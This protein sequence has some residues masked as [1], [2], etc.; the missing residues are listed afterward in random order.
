MHQTPEI[1]A[2]AAEIARLLPTDGA[3]HVLSGVLAVRRSAPSDAVVHA[4]HRPALCLVAQG[5]KA[6]YLDDAAYEY[7]PQQFLVFALDMPV[8]SQVLRAS[9]TTPYLGLRFDF[10]MVQLAELAARVF[11]GGIPLPKQTHAIQIGLMDPAVVA[12][13][14]RVLRIAGKPE[15]ERLFG[16]L[17]R[18]ELLLHVL[19]SPV[20]P[21]LAQMGNRDS[22]MSKISEAIRYIR[23]HYSDALDI[24]AIAARV[25][26]SVS[27]FH[28][29]FKAATAMSPL[30]YQKALRL[31][32]A[33]RLL[34]TTTMDSQH[35]AYTVGYAS[36]SQFSREYRRHFGETPSRDA[37]RMRTVV[38]GHARTEK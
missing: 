37:L 7:N 15:E 2:L 18:T 14:T 25:Y 5:A 27:S 26:M 33:R 28:Q 22:R 4:L 6:L 10:D 21:M 29:H 12:S 34:M 8:A 19:R 3:T 13:A 24:P 35:V 23:S 9:A 11:P 16:E 1:A 36:V 17:Y 32:E 20:G 31:Q 30:Q 38:P